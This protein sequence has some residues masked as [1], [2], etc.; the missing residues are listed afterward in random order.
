[1]HNGKNGWRAAWA[2]FSGRASFPSSK[3]KDEASLVRLHVEA[4]E[5]RL[6]PAVT[7]KFDYSYDSLGFFA[8]N[9]AAKTV[10]QE[11]GQLLGSQLHDSLAAIQPD[12]TD[13]WTAYFNRPNTE[14]GITR[15]NL[16]IPAN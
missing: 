6:A 11:A 15:K 1:M 5:D 14:T 7:F 4:L 3:R 16:T 10:L 8:K 2:W 12:A 13:R 9:P